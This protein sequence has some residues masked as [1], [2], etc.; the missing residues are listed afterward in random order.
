[1]AIILQ[2][3]EWGR[4]RGWEAVKWTVLW[5]TAQSISSGKALIVIETDFS[6]HFLFARKFLIFT[7]VE[8]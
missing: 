4:Y 2:R 5:Q 7:G 3:R 6:D 1:M 8:F